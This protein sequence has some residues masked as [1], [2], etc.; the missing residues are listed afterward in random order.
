M[1]AL[2]YTGPEALELREVA[3]PVGAHGDAVVRVACAGICG[4]DMHAF[5]GHD[6]RRPAPLILGH[7]AAGTTGDGRRVTINPLV[8]CGAC[9]ACAAGR[10]NLCAERQ[11]ISM[12]PREGAFAERVAMPPRN[13]IDVPAHVTDVQAALAEPLACGWNAARTGLT[14]TGRAEA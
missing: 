2:V 4:S 9:P 1:R 13:L 11:I 7:E 12:P 3:E 6:A 14:H 10:T 5:L 8:T